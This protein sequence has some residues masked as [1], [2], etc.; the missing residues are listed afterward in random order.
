[1][2]VPIIRP[3]E[4]SPAPGREY[5]EVIQPTSAEHLVETGRQRSE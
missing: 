4:A 1:M 5:E 2:G 3:L